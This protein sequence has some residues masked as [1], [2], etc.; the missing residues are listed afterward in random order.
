MYRCNTSIYSGNLSSFMNDTFN[1]SNINIEILIKFHSYTFAA[2]CSYYSYDS[3]ST[4][5]S[6]SSLPANHFLSILCF[7]SLFGL[8]SVSIVKLFVRDLSN[9][10]PPSYLN[11]FLGFLVGETDLK[12]VSDFVISTPSKFSYSNQKCLLA[13]KAVNL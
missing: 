6:S 3:M 8:S 7:R 1:K 2:S 10:K 9:R 4:K 5:T 11:V 12:K 13:S